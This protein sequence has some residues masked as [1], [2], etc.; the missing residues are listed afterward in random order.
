MIGNCN[1]FLIFLSQLQRLF[2][3]SFVT[4]NPCWSHSFFK[5]LS[6]NSLHMFMLIGLFNSITHD[7][8]SFFFSIFPVKES[9]QEILY[10]RN[11]TRSRDLVYGQFF[12][13]FHFLTFHFLTS[14]HI[15]D[16][17]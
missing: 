15:K 2:Y 11:F 8:E 17:K 12:G 16:E 7:W 9:G 1:V 5:S 3:I 14:I 10:T 6:K 13:E 4:T